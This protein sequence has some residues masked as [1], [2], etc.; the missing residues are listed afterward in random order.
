MEVPCPQIK[1]FHCNTYNIVYEIIC[2]KETC[3]QVYIGV[4]KRLL[5][6]Q[7]ADHRGYIVKKDT[8][9]STGHHLILAGHS[10]SDLSISVLEQV[11]KNNLVYRK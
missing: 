11:K 9:Q 6:C 8:N 4:T 1:K 2:K 10:H 3:K 7:L 5:K